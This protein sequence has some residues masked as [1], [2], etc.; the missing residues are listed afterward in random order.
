[1]KTVYEELGFSN[2][3]WRGIIAVLLLVGGGWLCV[4]GATGCDEE[5]KCT[6]GEWRCSED[7]LELKSCVGG[8]WETVRC[9]AD[10]GKLCQE[11]ACVAS[12]EYDDPEWDPCEGEA[13]AT[14]E[15]LYEKMIYFEDRAANLHIH[16]DL[17]WFS[18]VELPCK[19][20]ACTGGEEPPC[21]DCTQS[22]VAEE[23]ATWEDVA[24]WHTGEN[25]GLWSAL[26]LT[27]QAYRYGATGSAE[28]WRTSR[29]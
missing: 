26:Y 27:A 23:E 25:D 1:M 29:S 21:Y 11:G 22:A 10:E 9:M 13:A 2:R 8:R 5:K 24:Y 6:D 28:A 15:T 19:E 7:A 17:R 14:E 18:G 20:V 4:F 12:T 16:P 3:R